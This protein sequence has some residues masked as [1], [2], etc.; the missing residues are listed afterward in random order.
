LLRKQKTIQASTKQL[1]V[2]KTRKRI[3]NN[4]VNSTIYSVNG[5]PAQRSI[6]LSQSLHARSLSPLRKKNHIFYTSNYIMT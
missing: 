1:P 5:G 6:P 3:F 4:T 2:V